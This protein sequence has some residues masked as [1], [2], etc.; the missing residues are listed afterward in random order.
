MEIERL[1]QITRQRD[2]PST[3]FTI[4]F[5]HFSGNVYQYMCQDPSYILIDSK[6]W[7]KRK[8]Q[9]VSIAESLQKAPPLQHPDIVVFTPAHKTSERRVECIF[10]LTLRNFGCRCFYAL[11][12]NDPRYFISYNSKQCPI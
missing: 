3:A 6:Q 8:L 12:Q 1:L 11:S 2:T 4:P 5:Y 10:M 9:I 7:F